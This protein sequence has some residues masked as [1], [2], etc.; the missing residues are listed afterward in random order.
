MLLVAAPGLSAVGSFR[1][2]RSFSSSSTFSGS[3]P[4]VSSIP[5]MSLGISGL[6]S[7]EM[8]HFCSFSDPTVITVDDMQACSLAASHHMTG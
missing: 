4:S 5:T 3:I 6:R 2:S 8:S 7:P 1:L